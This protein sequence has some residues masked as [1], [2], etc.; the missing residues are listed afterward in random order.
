MQGYPNDIRG[1][2]HRRTRIDA[3]TLATQNRWRDRRKKERH[4]KR[5]ALMFMKRILLYCS[6]LLDLCAH[7]GV[8][9]TIMVNIQ[10]VI[11]EE[12]LGV[13]VIGGNI[14]YRSHGFG[15]EL[16]RVG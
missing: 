16:A 3:R 11:A 15:G 7:N 6:G 2:G 10:L 1:N 9:T 14:I 5:A 13:F 12:F 4:N 8:C